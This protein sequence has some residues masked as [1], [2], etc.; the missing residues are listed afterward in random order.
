MLLSSLS[1]PSTV[2]YYASSPAVLRM[3]TVRYP[4]TVKFEPHEFNQSQA[5]TEGCFRNPAVYERARCVRLMFEGR[6][7]LVGDDSAVKV[8]CHRPK[9][10]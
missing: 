4:E 1:N 10:R 6:L 3:G 2:Y 9:K 8:D 5:P 7:A